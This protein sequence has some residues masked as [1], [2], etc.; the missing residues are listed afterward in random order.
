[1]KRGSCHR[2]WA[3]SIGISAGRGSGNV[4]SLNKSI[5]LLAVP[6]AIRRR[7]NAGRRLRLRLR[8]RFKTAVLR[9]NEPNAK[10]LGLLLQLLI[11][12][13]KVRVLVRPPK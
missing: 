1:M 5:F 2:F 10:L 4:F 7:R 11:S 13:S 6:A 12:G 3:G 8:L 9:R